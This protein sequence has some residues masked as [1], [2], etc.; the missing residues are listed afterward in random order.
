MKAAIAR[1]ICFF[2]KHD[3]IVFR[4][5][6]LRLECHRC[7]CPHDDTLRDKWERWQRQRKQPPVKPTDDG[8]P[9]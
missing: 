3:L 7:H 8:L 2:T 6:T 5:H 4:T 1:L 9:F